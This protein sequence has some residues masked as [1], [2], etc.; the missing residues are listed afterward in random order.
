M[1]RWFLT[2]IL[3]TRPPNLVSGFLSAFEIDLRSREDWPQWCE[4]RATRH[5][6]THNWGRIDASYVDGG[7][8]AYEK[9]QQAD[10]RYTPRLPTGL[11]GTPKSGER[12]LRNPIDL[13][14]S[15]A[16]SSLD[17]GRR[18]I[19]DVESSL[20]T[21]VRQERIDWWSGDPYG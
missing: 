3:G 21:K 6:V 14:L 4:L 10:D 8:R 16:R 13:D 2:P 20:G 12:A 5:L 15:Y 1:T 17:L 11:G 19:D 18:I 9:N 7:A